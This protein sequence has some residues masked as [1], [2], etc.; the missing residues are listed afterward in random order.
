MDWVRN[1][2]ISDRVFSL[3]ISLK[4]Y[5]I[6]LLLV[7]IINSLIIYVLHYSLLCFI[8]L[9]LIGCILVLL[10][11]LF[12]LP[13]LLPIIIIILINNC[14]QSI[15]ILVGQL[16][17]YKMWQPCESSSPFICFCQ[18]LYNI[19]VFRCTH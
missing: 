19:G 9:N 12:L 8:N 11:L 1:T 13:V 3:L 2:I 18:L 10:F 6:I 14:M 15:I 4:K 16:F 7:F 5:C 17:T